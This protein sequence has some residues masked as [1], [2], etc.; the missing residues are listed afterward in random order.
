MRPLGNNAPIDLNSHSL[1]RQLES[2]EHL[3]YCRSNSKGMGLTVNRNSQHSA[4]QWAA[5]ASLAPSS[6]ETVQKEGIATR[7]VAQEHPG[8]KAIAT[9]GARLK[10]EERGAPPARPGDSLLLLSGSLCV[11]LDPEFFKIEQGV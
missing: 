1:T 8:E 10:G 4:K 7:R 5:G 2:L 6:F 3:P 11:D 9:R